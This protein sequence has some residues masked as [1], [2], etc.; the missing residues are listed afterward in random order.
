M[1]EAGE[2]CFAHVLS[3]IWIR[4]TRGWFELELAVKE[5]ETIIIG[6]TRRSGSDGVRCNVR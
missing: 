5:S 6:W 4:E 3:R 1:N 2:L